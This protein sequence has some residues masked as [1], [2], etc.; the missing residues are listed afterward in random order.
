M[1][2]LFVGFQ[3]ENHENIP[4]RGIPTG[5]PKEHFSSWGS[6]WEPES[7][8]P[9]KEAG[10]G[11]EGRACPALISGPQPLRH[12][13]RFLWPLRDWMGHSGTG[14]LGSH[15]PAFAPATSFH[16][17]L[18]APCPSRG[19]RNQGEDLQACN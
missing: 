9:D 10:Q 14:M 17:E 6:S 15:P 5:K 1:K 19:L 18:T 11:V 2:A 12:I 3:Q 4:A 7:M 8:L 16:A 13:E